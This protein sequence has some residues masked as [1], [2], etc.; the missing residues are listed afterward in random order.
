MTFNSPPDEYNNENEEQEE[1]NDTSTMV[2]DGSASNTIIEDFKQLGNESSTDEQ[3]QEV[4][5]SMIQKVLNTG[6]A[7]QFGFPDFNMSKDQIDQEVKNIFQFQDTTITNNMGMN[8][9][10][11]QTMQVQ[12]NVDQ[13]NDQQQVK[14]EEIYDIQ[15]TKKEEKKNGW[16]L[17]NENAKKPTVATQ[18]SAGLDVYSPKQFTIPAHKR[19]TLDLGIRYQFGPGHQQGNQEKQ[20]QEQ[21]K[22]IPFAQFAS[23]SGLYF[24]K[25]VDVFPGVIDADYPDEW[26]LC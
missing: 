8:P 14:I 9:M 17:L 3:K 10:T 13:E 19:V 21:K 20:E 11:I 1:E 15:N 7:Q 23:R 6:F 22:M 12:E 2:A 26:K 16:I 25:N 5:S 24:K 18:Q 4:F